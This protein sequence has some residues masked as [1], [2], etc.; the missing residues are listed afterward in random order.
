[1]AEFC[2]EEFDRLRIDKKAF[3]PG[4]LED[5][6]RV[7]RLC[8]ELV[9]SFYHE[10]VAAGFSPEEATLLAQ[11]ADYY[12]R[13]FVVSIRQ[14]SIFDEKPGIVK[15]FA[16]NWYIITTM[17]PNM[18]ELADFLQGIKAFYRYLHGH[19]LVSTKFLQTVERECD[20]L[21]YYEQRIE[22]FWSISGDGYSTWERECTL[23]D[24]GNAS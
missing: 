11:G 18:L 10:T 9:Q 19:C 8:K 16:G 24:S 7:D 6:L 15:K 17:E 2:E 21:D 4:T 1:M 20:D 13:D 23:K 22:S 5:E 3:V 14:Q 12:A